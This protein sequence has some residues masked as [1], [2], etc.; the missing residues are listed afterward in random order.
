MAAGGIMGGL[1][2]KNKDAP[3]AEESP[4][5]TQAAPTASDSV[6]METQSESSNFSSAAVPAA[7]LDVPAGFQKV[8]HQM[9]KALDRR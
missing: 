1:R 4:A 6:M 9:K 5:A 2:R 3:K 8:D 7:K